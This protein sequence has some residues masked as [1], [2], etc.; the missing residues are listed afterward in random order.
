MI[1]LVIMAGLAIA[2]AVVLAVFWEEIRAW[3]S[4]V[5]E[6][7]PPNVKEQFQGAKAYLERIEST[8]KNVFYYYSYNKQTQQWTETVVGREVSLQSIPEDI[9]KKMKGSS[10]VDITSDVLLKL[11]A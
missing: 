4:R 2:G 7:L 11:A 5:W 3:M 1:P 9:Q 8:I 10:K 6:K